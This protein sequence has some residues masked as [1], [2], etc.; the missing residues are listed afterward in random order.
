MTSP[1]HGHD[2]DTHGAIEPEL[3]ELFQEDT[4]TLE[5][6]VRL[7][8]PVGAYNLAARILHSYNAAVAQTS[9]PA[10]LEQIGTEDMRRM[11]VTIICTGNPIFIGPDKQLVANGRAGILPVGVP[12]TLPVTTPLWCAG[13]GGNATVSVWVGNWAD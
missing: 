11:F 12:I 5:V 4:G 2:Y 1:N 6:P 3:G 10:L 8:K 7:G 9:D 13:S